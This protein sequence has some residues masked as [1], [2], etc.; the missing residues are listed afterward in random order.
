MIVLLKLD[1]NKKKEII[2]N[3]DT[4]F[5]YPVKT[6]IIYPDNNLLEILDKETGDFLKNKDI[7]FV[8][9]SI[10]A[11][12][13][14]RVFKFSEIKYGKTAEILSNFVTKTSA[15][16]GLGTPQTMQLAINE[17][18]YLKIIFAAILA[19]VGK[20]FNKKGIFYKITGDK[21]RGIDGP[22][23]DTIPP[24]NEYAS[25]SPSN[26]KDFV[27][28]AEKFFQEKKKINLQFIVIDAND[29][30]V[31]ILG[32]KNNKEERLAKNLVADNPLGQSDQS[33][34]F[35]ICRK[36]DEL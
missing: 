13:E 9:E 1:N 32:A 30:G 14:G 4:Y 3:N 24:Y 7:V 36:K 16:I 20:I 34:P 35:L 23:S 26:P 2:F 19:G 22:T 21:V 27:K 5:R 17:V 25:L 18:G 15:G 33:T 10:I 11:I 6:K 28:K 31:N 29:L 12:S 8:A